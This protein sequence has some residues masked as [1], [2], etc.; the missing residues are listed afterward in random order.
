MSA[1]H[2]PDHAIAAAAADDAIPGV[3]VMRGW[4]SEDLEALAIREACGVIEACPPWEPGF[5][6][7]GPVPLKNAGAGALAWHARG[8]G[9]VYI[10]TQPDGTPLP[11]MP[12]LFQNDAEAVC[13]AYDPVFAAESLLINIYDRRGQSYRMHKDREEIV[14]AP[15]YSLSLGVD[16]DFLIGGHE[17][18]RDEIVKITLRSG[19]LLIMEGP[20]RDRFHGVGKVYYAR[21]HPV[22]G[23]MRLNVTVRMV[24][25]PADFGKPGA[26]TEPLLNPVYK[27]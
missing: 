8:D 3:H 15:I 17:M 22:L 1:S 20:A 12:P 10:D 27:G 2:M 19:D 25:P 4:F 5:P 21:P 9:N 7:Q 18:R 16:C 24:N 14:K 26:G 13:R 11:A 6:G 23:A